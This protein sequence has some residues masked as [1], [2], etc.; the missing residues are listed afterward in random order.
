MTPFYRWGKLS[1]IIYRTSEAEQTAVTPVPL[2]KSYHLCNSKHSL[3]VFFLGY[4]I[5]SPFSYLIQ[6][7][8]SCNVSV[9]L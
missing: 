6:I 8:T 7:K 1:R 3:L 2:L 5:F 4:S 9:S